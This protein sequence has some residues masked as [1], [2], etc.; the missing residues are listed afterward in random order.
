MPDE[1]QSLPEML[2]MLLRHGA[3]TAIADRHGKCPLYFACNRGYSKT[4][5]LLL[6]AGTD[7]GQL[8]SVRT[9]KDSDSQASDD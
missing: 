5:R 6:A 3:P 4:F 1:P 9:G 7:V 2:T 8:V